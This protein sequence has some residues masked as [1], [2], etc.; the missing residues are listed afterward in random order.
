MKKNKKSK[1]ETIIPLL[2]TMFI[3]GILGSGIGYYSMSLELSRMQL[4]LSFA[5]LAVAFVLHIIIHEAGHLV[6]GLLT[7]HTFL[8]YRVFSFCLIKQEGKFKMVRSKVPG[9]MGQ[10]LL[11]PPEMN[12]RHFP[13]QLYLLG[14]VIANLLFSALSFIFYLF[15]PIMVL[16]F[17][18]VGV[19]FFLLNGLPNGFNDGSTLKI[20][21]SSLN[22]ERLLYIQLASNAKMSTGS[23]FSELPEEYFLPVSEE[24]THT[25]FEDYQAFLTLGLLLE[26]QNWIDVDSY[27]EGLWLKREELIVPYQIE[28]K[29]EMLYFLLIHKKKEPQKTDARIEELMTDR[30]LAKYLQT[31]MVSNLRVVAGIQFAYEKKEDKALKTIQE[32]LQMK[33][34]TGN[35]G[36]FYVE[37]IL[38]KSLEEKINRKCEK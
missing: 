31:K 7:G 18:L 8:S 33:E 10:C 12:D 2:L 20:A 15:N 28:L 22:K 30:G 24:E 26:K 32:A 34:K 9:T 16:E 5:F 37:E 29:K 38:L 36:E 14:G 23:K 6:F 3:S 27:I 1:L 21:R 11:T 17:V 13:Y 35:L 25:Y 19:L 4:I